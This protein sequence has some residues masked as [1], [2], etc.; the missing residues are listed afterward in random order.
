MPI[1]E[2]ITRRKYVKRAAT[3]VLAPAI[4]GIAARQSEASDRRIPRVKPLP[5][6]LDTDIGDDIDDTWALVMLLKSPQFDLKLVTTTNGRAEYRG[7]LIAKLLS[8]AG[9]T[10]VSIGLGTGDQTGVGGQAEWGKDYR[11]GEYPGKVFADGAQAMIDTVDALAKAG[12]PATII[13]IGP[14]TTLDEVLKRSPATAAIA[15][16]V[17][18]DGSVRKGYD[19][20]PTPC[21]E[22]NMTYL[23]G[24][25][26]VFTAPWR[27]F[28]ITPLDTCG[29][30]RLRGG[31]CQHL[32]KS[33]DPLVQTMLENY[34]LWASKKSLAELTESSVLFDTVAVYLADPGPKP[35]L[36][37]ERLP[38]KVT[39]TGMTVIDPAGKPMAV[40]TNWTDLSAY[41]R[42][43]VEV[44]EQPVVKAA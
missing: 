24:S 44:L 40:A 20:S 8:L 34:R 43:L 2:P 41:E 23:P 17:G 33:A 35:L 4:V 42:H 37:I 36:E 5:V 27:S 1:D 22:C 39:E 3:A 16:F 13:A 10:D 21:L 31:L 19:N 7:K 9:R 29:L 32:V 12:T 38:I 30:V 14:L 18:M 25:Q 15:S 26:R 28:A 6:I 11:L